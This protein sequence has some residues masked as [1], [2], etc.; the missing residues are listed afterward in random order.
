LSAVNEVSIS[1]PNHGRIAKYKDFHVDTLRAYLTDD[2]EQCDQ[3]FADA[4]NAV[5]GKDWPSAEALFE[6][7]SLCTMRHFAREEEILFPAFETTTGMSGGPTVVM[8]H[9][10]AQILEILPAMNDAIGRRDASGYLGLSETLLMLLRQHNLK[11][12]QILYPMC[13][14]ALS[15]DA[16][17]LL[18]RMERQA[19]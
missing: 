15:G 8:R 1:L 19:V 11:E 3:L 12:E 9:E 16:P 10:H 17:A 4:E 6:R 7:F 18:E 5:D 2:H 14:R 13:D